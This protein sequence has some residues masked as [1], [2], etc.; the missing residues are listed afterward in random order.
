MWPSPLIHY[1]HPNHTD[2]IR[3]SISFNV[4]LEWSNDYAG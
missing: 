2:D 4:I 3:I 1:L